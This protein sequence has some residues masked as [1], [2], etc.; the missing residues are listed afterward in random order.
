MIYAF[1]CFFR[2]TREMCTFVGSQA[3]SSSRRNCFGSGNKKV[4]RSLLK[5]S[6][7]KLCLRRPGF[8]ETQQMYCI[9][10]Q[11]LHMESMWSVMAFLWQGDFLGS[12]DI[13][14][15][16]LHIM[17]FST[18]QIFLRFAMKDATSSL[19]LCHSPCLYELMLGD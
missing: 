6:K 5:S 15:A 19:S 7:I 3:T 14:N 4:S 16:Y 9:R 18:H 17:I 8:Q 2:C 11:K 13:K 10:V 1:K 12:I